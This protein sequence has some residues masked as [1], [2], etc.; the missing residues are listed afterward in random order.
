MPGEFTAKASIKN[1]TDTTRK[2][3]YDQD[4]TIDDVSERSFKVGRDYSFS[5]G[6]TL[7]Y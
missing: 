7:T 3:I 4:Q 1:L 6:Y 5:I 2:V